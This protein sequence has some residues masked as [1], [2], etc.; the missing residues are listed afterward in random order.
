MFCSLIT[1]I[2]FLL[3]NKNDFLEIIVYF[4]NYSDFFMGRSAHPTPPVLDKKIYG[5]AKVKWAQEYE[6]QWNNIF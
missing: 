5:D 1:C 2:S 3:L 6:H 4:C